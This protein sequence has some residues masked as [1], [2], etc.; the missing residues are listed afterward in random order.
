VHLSESVVIR[1]PIERAFDCWADLERAAEHQK[2][3]IDRTRLS[4][5]PVGKGTRY[6]AVD[7]W[8]GRKV[9]FEMEI[10]DFDRPSRIGA[11]WDE[12]MGGSWDSVF[13]QVGPNTR[14]DFETTIEPSGLMGLFTPLMKPWARRQLRDGLDSFRSWVESGNC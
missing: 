6:S 8:P 9:E 2:P 11:R 7:Q 10:T 13:S 12:P 5:G 3:T 4:D 1:A 14:M